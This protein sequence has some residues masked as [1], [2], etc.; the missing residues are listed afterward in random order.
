MRS[1]AI[2]AVALTI[3]LAT[4]LAAT[5]ESGNATH[6]LIDEILKLETEPCETP[7]YLVQ[8]AAIRGGWQITCEG[9]AMRPLLEVF[10][11]QD[12][13][14]VIQYAEEW[15]SDDGRASIIGMYLLAGRCSAKHLD[16]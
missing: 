10:D 2:A 1:L 11:P 8:D 9:C 15:Q 12:M 14:S 16:W 6:R 5:A 3:S 13:G 7:L 4:I